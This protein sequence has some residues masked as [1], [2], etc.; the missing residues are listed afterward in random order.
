M[1]DEAEVSGDEG[2]T[3]CEFIRHS[4]FDIISNF[5]IRHSS[6]FR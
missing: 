3:E 6:F 5:V 2:T 4:S 1:N